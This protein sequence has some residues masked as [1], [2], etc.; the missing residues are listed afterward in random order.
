VPL[1]GLQELLLL[2]DAIMIKKSMLRDLHPERAK[3]VRKAIAKFY[4]DDDDASDATE[5]KKELISSWQGM[6]IPHVSLPRLSNPFSSSNG[7]EEVV[8]VGE[9][10]PLNV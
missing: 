9:S 4:D 6:S 2:R 3:S 7:V 10:T 1:F 8:V 5:L